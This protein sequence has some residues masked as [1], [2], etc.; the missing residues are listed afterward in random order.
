VNTPELGL[1]INRPPL[2]SASRAIDSTDS[3]L[4]KPWFA[5]LAAAVAAVPLVVTAGP[6]WRDPLR[7]TDLWWL[8]RAGRDLLAGIV[9]RENGYSWTT[10]H[11]LW[12]CHELV[13][14]AVYAAIGPGRVGVAR[15]LLVSATALALARTAWRKESHIATILATSW[16]AFLVA[17]GHTERPLTW[18]NFFLAGLVALLTTTTWRGRH[19]AAAVLVGVWAWVHGS[20]VIG[21]LVLAVYSWRWAIAAG[22]LTLLN[23]Y[24]VHLWMLIGGYGAGAGSKAWVQ[25]HVPEWHPLDPHVALIALMLGA[26]AL[27]PLLALWRRDWRGVALAAVLLPLAVMHQRFIDVF[28]IALLPSLAS[29]LAALPRGRP[30][31]NPVWPAAAALAVMAVV[32][33]HAA[34][35]R[36][37]FPERL[38]PSIPAEARIWNDWPLGGWL[39]YHD[40]APFWDTRNDPYPLGVLE[41]GYLIASQSPGWRAVLDKWQIAYVITASPGLVDA[42]TAERWVDVASDGQTRLL[43]RPTSSASPPASP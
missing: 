14:A 18:G 29:G 5:V 31:A 24:G 38:L 23:P 2:V 35:D 17:F 21:L 3:I 39:A 34:V 27:A 32:A 43:R 26:A 20:F 9:P 40:R 13:V 37:A 7:D 6:A 10:P 36:T 41:D 28:A 4:T 11:E 33:P 30:I 42:L 19:A 15:G 1:E 12:I 22:G 25:A 16:A 8:M